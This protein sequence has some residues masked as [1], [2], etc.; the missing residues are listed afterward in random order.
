MSEN[1]APMRYPTNRPG[2]LGEGQPWPCGRCGKE[3]DNLDKHACP[4][5][6]TIH[7]VKH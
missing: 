7:G 3:E 2:W 5:V 4:E 6:C 1:E